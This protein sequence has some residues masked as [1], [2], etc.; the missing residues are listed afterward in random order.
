MSP[1]TDQPGAREAHGNG[2]SNRVAH[3]RAPML[4]PSLGRRAVVWLPQGLA[5]KASTMFMME[6]IW[7]APRVAY[8]R[9]PISDSRR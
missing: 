5:D 7:D 2:D 1:R 9:Q 3:S 4:G 6:R 8:T